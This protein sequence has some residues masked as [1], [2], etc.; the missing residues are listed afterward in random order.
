MFS[1]DFNGYA[2][3]IKN[4]FDDIAVLVDREFDDQDGDEILNDAE[5]AEVQ[6]DTGTLPAALKITIKFAYDQGLKEELGDEDFNNWIAEVFTHTQA[7]FLQADSL[8]SS[9]VFDVQGDAHYQDGVVWRSEDKIYDARDVTNSLGLDTVDVMAWWTSSYNFHKA[10]YNN[11]DNTA[12][13]M[14]FV[15]VLCGYSKVSINEKQ[16]YAAGSG[17]V[18][19]HELGHNFGMSHDFSSKHGGDDGPC[20]G[21]GIMSYGSY[22]YDQWSSCSQ[23]DFKE[24]YFGLNWETCLEDISDCSDCVPT[25]TTTTTTPTPC[26]HCRR[27]EL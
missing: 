18:L 15:G 26:E 6:G 8:G 14:G 24:H 13:G 11:E 27:F 21:Q 25:T 17:F 22:S 3:I 2:D 4:P 23:S 1:V 20:N 19:A 5:E 7:H 12:A 10:T 9:V 16:S